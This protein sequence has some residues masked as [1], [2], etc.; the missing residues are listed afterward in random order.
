MD[1]IR[2]QTNEL[3][4]TSFCKLALEAMTAMNRVARKTR[5]DAPKILTIRQVGDI[6]GLG[7]AVPRGKGYI[8]IAE[9]PM[10]VLEE[11]ADEQ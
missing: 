6:I 1:E 8:T 3:A 11:G 4:L 9:L 2:I 7:I 10:G 5:M